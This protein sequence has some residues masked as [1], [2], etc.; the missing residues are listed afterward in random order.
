MALGVELREGSAH[1]GARVAYIQLL[2][3]HLRGEA[4]ALLVVPGAT[5]LSPQAGAHLAGMHHV[6]GT[7]VKALAF[8]R[9]A[10]PVV[11]DVDQT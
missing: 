2:G 9:V 6:P 5:E 8:H 3:D 10:R 11:A 4:L 7:V 1:G